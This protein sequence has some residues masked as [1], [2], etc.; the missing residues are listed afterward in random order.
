M[1]L[2]SPDVRKLLYFYPIRIKIKLRF[3]FYV[4]IILYLWEKFKSMFWFFKY[5]NI[6]VSIYVTFLKSNNS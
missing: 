5:L 3:E 6:K 4:S 2:Y 1:Q